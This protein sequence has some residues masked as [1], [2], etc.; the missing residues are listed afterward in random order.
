MRRSR[1]G[2]YLLHVHTSKVLWLPMIVYQLGGWRVCGLKDG[3]QKII[4]GGWG[5]NWGFGTVHTGT[6]QCHRP[7]MGLKTGVRGGVVRQELEG[8]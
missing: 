1:G 2:A 3:K 8:N 6:H 7:R 4:S 5:A